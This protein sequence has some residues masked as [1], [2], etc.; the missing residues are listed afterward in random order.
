MYFYLVNFN[1]IYDSILVIQ[2]KIKPLF[3]F[4]LVL[5]EIA[6]VN[7]YGAYTDTDKLRIVKEELIRLFHLLFLCFLSFLLQNILVVCKNIV[8]SCVVLYR[9][10]NISCVQHSIFQAYNFLGGRGYTL[11]TYKYDKPVFFFKKCFSYFLHSIKSKQI[12][13]LALKKDILQRKKKIY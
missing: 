5:V 10:K 8:K 6:E 7:N 1:F 11:Y 2:I 3:S 13:S 4:F 9:C 12:K